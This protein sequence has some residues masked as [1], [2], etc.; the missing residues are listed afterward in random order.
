MPK[1]F[2]TDEFFYEIVSHKQYSTP[3]PKLKGFFRA[4][5]VRFLRSGQMATFFSYLYINLIIF[6]AII[7]EKSGKVAKKLKTLA[8]QRFFV[9]TFGFK[10]GQKPTF[11][12]Q[13][14][15]FN[16]RP[17]TIR[18]QKVFKSGQMAI[19][20]KKSGQSFREFFRPRFFQF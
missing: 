12:G 20:Q 15:N 4:I 17:A 3:G 10:S 14:I 8:P 7:K 19:F 16:P 6:F 5:L 11:F 18:T 13:K 1:Y 9:A 2:P